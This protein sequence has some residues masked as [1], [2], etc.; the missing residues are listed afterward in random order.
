MADITESHHWTPPAK[1]DGAVGNA[2]GTHAGSDQPMVAG[3]SSTVLP[4]RRMALEP[5]RVG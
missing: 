2:G 3:S 5:Q 1:T 4:G